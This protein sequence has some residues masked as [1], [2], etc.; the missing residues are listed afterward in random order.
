[1][2]KRI[3]CAVMSLIIILSFGTV[4]AQS[5]INPRIDQANAHLP[6]ITA[7]INLEDSQGNLID[8]GNLAE[9]DIIATLDSKKLDIVSLSSQ[10][11]SGYGVTYYYLL[12][13]STSI[14]VNNLNKVKES[15]LKHIERKSSADKIVVISFG[16][17][18]EI[19]LEGDETA[20]EAQIELN[21]ILPLQDGTRL[22]DAVTKAIELSSAKSEYTGERSVVIL[23][24][25][26][27]DEITGGATKQELSDSLLNGAMSV[28]ALGYENG[29][30]S[31]LNSLGEL[32][33]K[34]GGD[35]ALVN[36]SNIAEA[37]DGIISKIQN[38]L[39]LECKAEKNY[40]E[41][42]LG[43]LSLEINIDNE[44]YHTSKSVYY[45]SSIQDDIAP[46]ITSILVT[47]KTHI[48]V[49]FSEAV[50]NADKIDSFLLTDL[51][52]NVINISSVYY[53]E[54]DL[55]AVLTTAET[56]YEGEYIL[57]ALNITDISYEKNGL[58]STEKEFST[59][60]NPKDMKYFWNNYYYILIIGLVIS[61]VVVILLVLTKK[62]RLPEKVE[63]SVS[64]ER[65]ADNI[66]LGKMDGIAVE[67]TVI[68]AN[69]IERKVNTVISGI[70]IVGRDA[71]LCELAIEDKRMSRQHFA[72]MNDN[73][74]LKVRDLN[75]TN[76]TGLN[77][78]AISNDRVINSND[79]IEAGNIRIRISKK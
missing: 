27:V 30:Q 63:S 57:Q 75:S 73:G 48:E 22:Y 7:Y 34:S 12:D 64:V 71:A 76:G 14:S 59:Q 74:V 10:K 36:G 26:G 45:G 2:G 8:I 43:N 62:K 51:K 42:T 25:D 1:M 54:D 53:N 52:A 77:G 17:E 33:R 58:T 78:M 56:L 66:Y 55:T 41:N 79:I 3:V 9:A 35:I 19:I 44:M 4:S 46:K 67:L 11:D 60:T 24:T 40:S 69:H 21:S 49:E 5:W 28:Y 37:L 6:Y 18:V 70:Y 29:S 50:V 72:L 61:G 65:T 38:S 31:A 15:I 39:R 68:D 23:A 13:A 47:D 32:S 16:T 20:S